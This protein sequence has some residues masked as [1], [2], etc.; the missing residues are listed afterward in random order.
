[1]NNKEFK[2]LKLISKVKLDESGKAAKCLK[3]SWIIFRLN[4]LGVSPERIREII[5]AFKKE[6][7]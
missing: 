7:S 5:K 3:N 1:M 6:G 2:A 4:W